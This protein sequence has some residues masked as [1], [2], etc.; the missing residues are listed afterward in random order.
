[1]EIFFLNTLSLKI[2][3]NNR[4]ISFFVGDC[5]SLNKRLAQL[6]LIHVIM[7][8]A[9]ARAHVPRLSSFALNELRRGNGA[10]RLRE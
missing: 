6:Y 10:E 4:K 1:M 7:R 5:K 8:A 2:K 9:A 3:N